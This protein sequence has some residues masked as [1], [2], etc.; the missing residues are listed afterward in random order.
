MTLAWFGRPGPRPM[1]DRGARNPAPLSAG[2]IMYV[3]GDDRIFGMDAYN[4]SILWTV[5][6][7]E[8]IRTNVKADSTNMICDDERL[9]V[10]V[11]D[12]CWV[13]EGATAT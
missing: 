7:P 13:I 8:L 5:E 3:Q 9:Y 2:G 4:G 12:S 1:R 10:A 6:I 11:A